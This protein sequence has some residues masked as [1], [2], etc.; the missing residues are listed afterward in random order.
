MTDSL[1]FPCVRNVDVQIV[2]HE[3]IRSAL[4]CGSTG[5]EA[6]KIAAL[7]HLASQLAAIEAS[8][9]SALA[10]AVER[11]TVTAEASVQRHLERGQG[12]WEFLFGV[13]PA[14]A[15]ARARRHVHA[16]HSQFMRTCLDYSMDI[17]RRR[18]QL[19]EFVAQRQQEC[20]AS[21]ERMLTKLLPTT[22]SSLLTDDEIRVEGM[23]TVP[24]RVM[25]EN[26]E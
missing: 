3:I 5:L 22:A 12:L 9:A 25:R 23:R 14:V 10:L 15:E 26:P 13:R 19:L 11:L 17:F 7:E 24:F 18:L 8:L 21:V 6:R 20:E 1:E 4:Q 16:L 2:V